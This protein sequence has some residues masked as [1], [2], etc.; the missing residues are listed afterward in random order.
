MDKEKRSKYLEII[1]Q[2]PILK[3][4]QLAGL[5]LWLESSDIGMLGCINFT[6]LEIE[7]AI[8]LAKKD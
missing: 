6:E 4:F 1:S 2:L 3:R 5:E 8:E 7:Q